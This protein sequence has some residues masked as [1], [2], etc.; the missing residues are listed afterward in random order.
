MLPAILTVQ[1]IEQPLDIDIK[2]VN[3]DT[4]DSL[5]QICS[6]LQDSFSNQDE[7]LNDSS[8]NVEKNNL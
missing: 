7:I 1:S 3:D 5:I 6:A 8:S 2:G 4:R